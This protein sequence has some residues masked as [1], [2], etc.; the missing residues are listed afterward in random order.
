MTGHVSIT[1]ASE[2]VNHSV[3][4]SNEL[5]RFYTPGEVISGMQDFMRWEIYSV[6]LCLSLGLT[7]KMNGYS[8]LIHISFQRPWNIHRRRQSQVFSSWCH[9]ESEQINLHPS[10]EE[11]LCGRDRWRGGRSSPGGTAAQVEDRDQLPLGLCTTA[12][13]C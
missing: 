10:V 5:P 8:L 12:L 4:G 7:N 13:L 6:L 11:S 3:A 9:A 1:L 2:R